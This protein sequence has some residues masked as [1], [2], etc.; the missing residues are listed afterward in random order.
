M[1]NV[2]QLTCMNTNAHQRYTAQEGSDISTSRT[3]LLLLATKTSNTNTLM[4]YWKESLKK[5]KL[6]S[7]LNP[8]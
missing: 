4:P 6:L 1:K 7:E 5:N 8:K 2:Q 3:N